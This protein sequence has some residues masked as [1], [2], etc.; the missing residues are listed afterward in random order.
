MDV[1]AD[2]FL[3]VAGQFQLGSLETEAQHPL[4]LNLSAQAQEDVPAAIRSLHAVD[5]QAMEKFS[6][7]AGE[8][9]D[10]ARAVGETLAA[11]R[12][13]FRR[14]CGATGR[15][16]LSLETFNREG[17]LLAP[18]NEERV[19]AFMAGGDLALIKSV[20]KFEDHPE[21]GAR[22]LEEAGFCPGDLLIASTE[23]G[24]TPWVIGAAERAAQ[25]SANAPWFLYCNP[26]A[27]LCASVE[28]SRRVIE[29]PDMRKLNLSVGPM[30]LSGSTRMQAST[31]QMAAIGFALRHPDSP[32]R[33]AEECAEF[34]RETSALDLTF[35]APFIE[36]EA[37]C[38]QSGE[39]VLY[40]PGAYGMTVLT[41]TTERSPTFSLLPFE[42]QNRPE[43][44]PS[45][46]H[47]FTPG[48]ADG[49]SAWRALLHR[50]P[51][52][53]EW[54]EARGV[55]GRA[56][57]DG[58]DFSDRFLA[59]RRQRHPALRHRHFRIRDDGRRL[60]FE[61]EELRHAMELG[62]M[63]GFRRHQV[64][65]MALNI[66][67]T[68][69]MGRLG[70]YLDNLMTYV[71]PSNLKLIDRSIRYVSQLLKRH[72]GCAPD[73]ETVARQ[74]FVERDRLRPEEPIVL[75]T[76]QALMPAAAG[77]E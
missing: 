23:G 4:T 41:D 68:T 17:L 7:R 74:L 8:V 18:G 20:E 70:R 53:L 14:G 26:D 21:Y 5:A 61:F 59:L 16:S 43:E 56:V 57:F 31:V 54:P 25:L 27:L 60:H 71:K 75:K 3:S 45:W 50:E 12:K 63:P 2:Q 37:A 35:L 65:K 44:Q 42:N 38:Y 76:M 39:R 29:N 77:A 48:Q 64:L 32:S 58:Y 36:K 10:L 66:L 19:L 34:C 52:T 30:A 15:L 55:A 51:R 13:I 33:A 22:Q 28:R 62:D 67:S 40:E 1:D 47:L 24:E 73:Y 72:A 46:C 69:V 9:A 11:G 6:L 49:P